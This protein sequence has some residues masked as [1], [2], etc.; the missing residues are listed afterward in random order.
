MPIV[1]PDYVQVGCHKYGISYPHSFREAVRIFGQCDN[2]LHEIRI[3]EMDQGGGRRPDSAIVATF[4]HEMLHAIDS[5]YMNGKVADMPEADREM[6]ISQFA[7]GLA[8]AFLS[9]QL[10][11]VMED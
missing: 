7:E 4:F 9:G 8:Q 5:I 11:D 3:S 10:P 6:I 2:C 1:F